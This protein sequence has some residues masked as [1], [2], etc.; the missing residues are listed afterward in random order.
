MLNTLEEKQTSKPFFIDG[1]VYVARITSAEQ[2]K[3][4]PLNEV[5][6]EIRKTLA[7]LQL[8]QAISS[9]SDEILKTVKVEYSK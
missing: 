2:Q 9:I 6:A 5:S 8:Q 3:A 7:P 1:K 4:R